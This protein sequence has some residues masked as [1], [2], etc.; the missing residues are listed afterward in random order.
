MKFVAD[1]S[2]DRQIIERLRDEGHSV[3]YVAEMAPAI[4]DDEVLQIANNGTAPLITSDKDFGEL[5]FRQ[6]L[7]SYGVILIRLSGLSTA[8]KSN[9]VSSAIINYKK[10]ILG[11]FTVVSPTRIRIRKI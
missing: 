6:H 8:L 1:E 11:N 10:E 9:I 4:S 7:V 2:V 5:V 3:W